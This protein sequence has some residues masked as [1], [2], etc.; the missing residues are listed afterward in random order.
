[1]LGQRERKILQR[2][3]ITTAIIFC[4]CLAVVW[5]AGTRNMITKISDPLLEQMHG[6]SASW[7]NY[8]N[9][10]QS[11]VAAN[12]EIERLMTLSNHLI[13]DKGEYERLKRENVEL[14]QMVKYESPEK[15]RAEPCGVLAYDIASE[16]KLIMIS[17]GTERGVVRG[18]AVLAP[19]GIMVG[20]ISSSEANRST[21]QML[22]DPMSKVA[23]EVSGVSDSQ[24]VA[25]P[26]GGGA[27]ALRYLGENVKVEPSSI[28]QTSGLLDSVPAG[29]PIGTID[30][31]V[32]EV[33][34]PFQR[35][36]ILTPIDAA[37]LTLVNVLINL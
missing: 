7:Q 10:K 1:M 25:M 26:V 20:T 12:M 4:I 37:S 16:R 5:F 2:K 17:C 35:A 32:K 8:K 18:E 31:T 3:R 9:T 19:N 33:D 28:I 14:R 15:F 34:T 27:L 22:K 30:S 23:A 29:I 21:V 24:G 11:L 6:I 36:I 13:I